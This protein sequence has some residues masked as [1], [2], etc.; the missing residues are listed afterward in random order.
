MKKLLILPLLTLFAF[1][2]PAWSLPGHSLQQEQQWASQNEF[3]LQLQESQDEKGTVYSSERVTSTGSRIR[4]EARLKPGTSPVIHAESL[5]IFPSSQ[6]MNN[7][8]MKHHFESQ[9]KT[10]FSSLMNVIYGP[11]IMPD[12]ESIEMDI[13]LSTQED[14]RFYYRGRKYGYVF[15]INAKNTFS[16]S[17][18]DIKDYQGILSAAKA[19]KKTQPVELNLFH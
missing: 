8:D 4:F 13:R 6:D 18:Y 5:L 3:L 15:D 11:V 16:L 12:Y 2:I 7:K 10:L 19:E 17:I 9:H 1:P 14:L